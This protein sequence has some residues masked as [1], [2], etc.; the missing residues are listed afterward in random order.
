MQSLKLLVSSTHALYLIEFS[1]SHSAAMLHLSLYS[2]V[3]FMAT[4]FFLKMLIA[5]LSSCGFIAQD[6]LLILIRFMS[7]SQMQELT[8]ISTPS[9][10]LL[11]NFGII[12]L[13]L[14]HSFLRLENFHK[15][16]SRHK[17]FRYFLGA[18][19]RGFYLMLPWLLASLPCM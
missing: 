3:I 6:F 17:T 18:A 13:I 7:I 11:V 4:L 9:S 10:Q 14:F 8:T 12:Y 2:V 1:Y 19:L 5:S 15:R 16:A